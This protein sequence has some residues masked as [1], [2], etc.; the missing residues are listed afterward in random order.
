MQYCDHT[1]FIMRLTCVGVDVALGA[2]VVELR[3]TDE[4][5]VRNC[6]LF[7]IVGY[8]MYRLSAQCLC[9]LAA[10]MSD[11]IALYHGSF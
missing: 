5:Y 4:D 3:L 6:C 9:F 1:E 10:I 2:G 7:R 11:F 8:F